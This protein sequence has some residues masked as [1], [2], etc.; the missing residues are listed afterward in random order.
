MVNFCTCR[1]TFLQCLHLAYCLCVLP[2]LQGR[3][4]RIDRLYRHLEFSLAL[5]LIVTKLTR[6]ATY[7]LFLVHWVSWLKGHIDRRV[8][9]VA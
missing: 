3:M 6:I 1:P 4:Y 7:A 5:P 9:H 2:V 8:S